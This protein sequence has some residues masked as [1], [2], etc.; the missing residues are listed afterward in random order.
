MESIFAPP[1][2]FNHPHFVTINSEGLMLLR[3]ARLV[4]FL[5]LLSGYGCATVING[6][7]Q[8]IPVSSD[9]SAAN[10]TV[11]GQPNT[12]TTPCNVELSRKSDHTLKIE[13]EG[14]EPA[15]VQITHVVS[16]AVAGNILLGG[17]IGVGVDAVSGGMNRL[18]PE[19]VNVTLR[20]SPPV[21]AVPPPEPEPPQAVEP[22]KP[23][24]LVAELAELDKMKEEKKIT[25]KEYKALRKKILDKY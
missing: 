21:V 22:A 15:S 24:G 13:K 1:L 20:S 5:A 17:L 10:V 8:K 18:V 7:T 6:T 3:V 14:F 2:Y 11:V 16:G 25:A 23:T 9:P 19:S 12:S 4:C